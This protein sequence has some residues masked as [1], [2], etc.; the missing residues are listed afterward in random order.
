MMLAGRWTRQL[1]LCDER[2]ETQWRVTGGIRQAHAAAD[3]GG[4]PGLMRGLAGCQRFWDG[5]GWS[6]QALR[7]VVSPSDKPGFV[8][9]GAGQASQRVS[10]CGGLFWPGPG[11]GRCRL[12]QILLAGRGPAQVEG[13]LR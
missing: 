2:L 13:P 3:L 4:A 9:L 6:R 1:L 7:C 10:G 5:V 11:S 12:H 8:P